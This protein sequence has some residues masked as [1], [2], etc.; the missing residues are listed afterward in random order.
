MIDTTLAGCAQ[1]AIDSFMAAFRALR[2][3]SGRTA[4]RIHDTSPRECGQSQDFRI[5]LSDD[6]VCEVQWTQPFGIPDSPQ[7]QDVPM[8]DTTPGKSS[9]HTDPEVAAAI[10]EALARPQEPAESCGNCRFRRDGGCHLKAPMGDSG[11]NVLKWPLV[12]V[13]DWCGEWQAIRA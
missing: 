5:F 7:Q 10:A 2:D 1:V 13:D 8:I 6:T 4:I 12:S 11:F 9:N 3:T